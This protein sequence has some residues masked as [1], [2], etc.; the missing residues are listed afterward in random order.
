VNGDV[1]SDV[2]V[3]TGFTSHWIKVG[4]IEQSWDDIDLRLRTTLKSPPGT[5]FDLYVYADSCNTPTAKSENLTG[6]DI[7]SIDLP[8]YLGSDSQ[9]VLVEVRAVGGHSDPMT[10]DASKQWTLTLEGNK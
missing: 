2:Q 8:D 6:D 3:V 1:G 4:L 9:W 7:A 10:C 5:N